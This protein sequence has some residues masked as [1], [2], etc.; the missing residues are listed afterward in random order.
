MLPCGHW[1][2]LGERCE[3]CGH[4]TTPS[5]FYLDDAN[6]PTL[7]QGQAT[8]CY[9]SWLETNIP[10]LFTKLSRVANKSANM[11]TPSLALPVSEPANILQTANKDVCKCGAPARPRGTDCWK[12]YR[13]RH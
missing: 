1:H 13:Q 2:R 6:Q 4:I 7:S 8:I 12:C 11:Q 5:R 3:Y 10:P 9:L